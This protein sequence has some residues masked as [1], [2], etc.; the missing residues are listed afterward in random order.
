MR[1]FLAPRCMQPNQSCALLLETYIRVLITP[2]ACLLVVRPL[3][4]L[5]SVL[6]RCLFCVLC[7]LACL[8]CF[9]LFDDYFSG[10]FFFFLR[11]TW[12][13]KSS[14]VGCERLEG[15]E[16]WKSGGGMKTRGAFAPSRGK[17]NVPHN[18]YFVCTQPHETIP[19]GPRLS[20]WRDL[21]TC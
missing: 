8:L 5:A 13:R 20:L 7:L 19:R 14:S 4:T 3:L 9:R 16:R 15:N 1:R 11:C 12:R 6:V 18:I 10:S 17:N 2:F 21:R